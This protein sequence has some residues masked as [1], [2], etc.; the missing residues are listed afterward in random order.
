MIYRTG[1]SEPQE[2]MVPRAR[3]PQALV[4]IELIKEAPGMAVLRKKAGH[5][6][7]ALLASLQQ[8]FQEQA[9]ER[10]E[11]RGH[12]PE[13]SGMNINKTIE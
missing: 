8:S 5:T 6:T 1:L 2:E 10:R 7:E 12:P 4:E 13:F 3:R 9:L 11:I